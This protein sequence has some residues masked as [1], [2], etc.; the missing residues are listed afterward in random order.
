MEAAPKIVIFAVGS[1]E[2][3][4]EAIELNAFQRRTR[5]AFADGLGFIGGNAVDLDRVELVEAFALQKSVSGDVV[6]R[7]AEI[8]EQWRAAF[9]ARACGDR[10]EE[11]RVGKEC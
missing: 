10:S 8:S 6:K 4:A 11:R 1:A 5:A 7:K 2:E 9:G 3:C